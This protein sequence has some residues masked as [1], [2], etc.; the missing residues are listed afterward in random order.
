MEDTAS[1]LLWDVHGKA[2][3]VLCKQSG[4]HAQGLQA[5][6]RAYRHVLTQTML[7]KLRHLDFAL[8]LSKHIT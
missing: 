2:L 6:S 5:A 4:T 1:G 7:R 3:R 8:S